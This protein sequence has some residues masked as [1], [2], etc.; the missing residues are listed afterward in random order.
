MQHV[1]YEKMCVSKI[2]LLYQTVWNKLDQGSGCIAALKRAEKE[3]K[4]HYSIIYKDLALGLKCVVFHQ[5]PKVSPETNVN[6]CFKF[7][8]VYGY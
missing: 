7:P 1:V 4:H 3:K 6:G 8:E 5:C 2:Y